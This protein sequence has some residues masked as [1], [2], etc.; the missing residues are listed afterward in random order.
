[1]LAARFLPSSSIGYKKIQRTLYYVR[2]YSAI[3]SEHHTITNVDSNVSIETNPENIS[4]QHQLNA[5]VI[6]K[7]NSIAEEQKGEEEEDIEVTTSLFK[8][9]LKQKFLPEYVSLTKFNDESTL[10]PELSHDLPKTLFSP[11]VHY[12]TDPRTGH[13]NFDKSLLDIPHI[14]KLKMDKISNFTPSSRDTKLLTIASTLNKKK[15]K[16]HPNSKSPAIKFFSSTSS[17]TGVLT[18]FHKFLSNNRPINTTSFSK[19]YP[20]TTNFTSTSDVPTSLVVTPKDSTTGTYSIDADRSTDSEITLSVLGNALE[21]MLTKSEEEFKK[22]LKSSKETPNE[23][24]SAYHY[25]KIGKF[26][27]RSQLDAVDNR[28]PGSGTFDIKTRAVCAIRFDL[29]HT[30][31]YPTNYEINKTY[32]LFESF[33]REL[34]DAARIVMFK[35]SLQ[36]RLGNMDGIFMA[37]HN[38]KKFLGFQYLP[39]SDIDNLFFGDYSLNGQRYGT[40]I[41]EKK[42]EESDDDINISNQ[43][44]LQNIVDDFGNHHQ[45]K[46]EL[47][48]SFI[49][50]YE[51]R[52]SINLLE[53]LLDKIIKD[54]EGKPFRMIVK[55]VKNSFISSH[56]TVVNTESPETNNLE[57]DTESSQEAILKNNT[58]PSQESILKNN[59]EDSQSSIVVLVNTL[60]PEELQEL[61]MLSKE[62]VEESKNVLK[63]AQSSKMSASDRVK[64]FSK[65]VTEFRSKFF[66][67]NRHIL[68]NSENDGFF[69]YQLKADHYFNGAK[70]ESRYPIPSIDILDKNKQYTW[71]VG[72]EI[73][74]INRMADKKYLYTKFIKNIAFTSFR[75]A[76]SESNVDVY[77]K[78]GGI[79]LDDNA[80]HLQNIMRAYSVKALRRKDLEKSD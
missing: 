14:D 59:I 5:D 75:E 13:L 55:K 54:T 32:G 80:T 6:K 36:A 11:G 61:Q 79:Q 15:Q 42:T 53:K 44:I 27:V 74:S 33:E 26:L 69:A 49:A 48:S 40:N 52:I 72:Y 23:D 60:L 10:V 70:C 21:L 76:D 28:L 20:A 77:P 41:L 29:S 67:L 56:E 16:K 37:F 12:L 17:M 45:T 43:L 35:Y 9:V 78:E 7:L 3:N 66:R 51:L 4:T 62:K 1:M 58:E 57:K 34:F 39:L 22:F 47:L 71:D 65:Y 30:D 50:D 19:Y 68:K 73:K 64:F 38:I 46:R 18:K 24:Q 25:A 63:N 2:K 8:G 31:Y